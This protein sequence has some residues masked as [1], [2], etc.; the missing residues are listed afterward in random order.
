MLFQPTLV[1]YL[2]HAGIQYLLIGSSLRGEWELLSLSSAE[3]FNQVWEMKSFFWS[4]SGWRQSKQ[5]YTVCGNSHVLQAHFYVLILYILVSGIVFFLVAV[6]DI[7]VKSQSHWCCFC[8]YSMMLCMF[9]DGH[10]FCICADEGEK[11]HANQLKWRDLKMQHVWRSSG[12]HSQMFCYII[13]GWRQWSFTHISRG[14]IHSNI[15]QT[16]LSAW[17]YR[18]FGWFSH[19]TFILFSLFLIANIPELLRRDIFTFSWIDAIIQSSLV[20]IFLS[21]A[22]KARQEDRW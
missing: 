11:I 7:G 8:I 16:L 21:F 6:T 13:W 15:W 12:V 4:S 5:S 1:I 2:W 19:F 3:I 9:R 18:L 14:Q 10:L 20:F 22:N 17:K